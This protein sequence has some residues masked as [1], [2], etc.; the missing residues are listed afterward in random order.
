MMTAHEGLHHMLLQS[1][2]NDPG[3]IVKTHF[4]WSSEPSC[5]KPS[6][7]KLIASLVNEIK[8]SNVLCLIKH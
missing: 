1:F 4:I 2:K 6:C 7:S 3:M 8:F 5:S